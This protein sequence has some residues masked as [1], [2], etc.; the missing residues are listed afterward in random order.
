MSHKQAKIE[1]DRLAELQAL[2][3]QKNKEEVTHYIMD[4]RAAFDMD[5][6]IVLSCCDTLKE[7]KKEMRDYGRGNCVAIR[8]NK[9]Q[10]MVVFID[11]LEGK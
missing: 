2:R 5:A 8:N 1:A 11:S 3:Q 9:D 10:L 4:S 7:A 6:A